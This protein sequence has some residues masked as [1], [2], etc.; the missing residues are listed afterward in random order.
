MGPR[1]AGCLT[2]LLTCSQDQTSSVRGGRLASQ[3][4]DCCIYIA[5]I[6]SRR[7]SA[8]TKSELALNAFTHPRSALTNNVCA[9]LYSSKDKPNESTQRWSSSTS[10]HRTSV[11]CASD[12]HTLRRRNLRAQSLMSMSVK[13]SLQMSQNIPRSSSRRST[14]SSDLSR[15]LRATRACEQKMDSVL[16][17]RSKKL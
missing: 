15:V 14:R 13:P 12:A 2:P 9:E 3:S 6:G 7:R 1:G 16:V 8:N 4:V 10:A 11:K 5:D 17:V